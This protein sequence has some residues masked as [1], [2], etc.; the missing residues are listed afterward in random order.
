VR[1][2]CHKSSLPLLTLILATSLTASAQHLKSRTVERAESEG[3]VA[4]TGL[5]IDGQPGLPNGP[6]VAGKDW[7]KSLRLDIK[8]NHDTAIVYMS[9]ELE[10][11]PTGKMQHPLR[12]PIHFGR[13]PGNANDTRDPKAVEKLAPKKMKRLAIE[14]YMYDFLV[15]YMKE[16][17]VNDIER[18]QMYVEIIIFDDGTAWGKGGHLM[19]QDPKNPDRWVVGG[20]WVD[21]SISSLRRMYG[22]PPPQPPQR[23]PPA[24]NTSPR[25]CSQPTKNRTFS[26]ASVAYKSRCCRSAALKKS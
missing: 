11:A 18:V 23:Q 8:N 12:L 5:E 4:V 9:V 6:V 25:L 16:N 1:L 24:Q 15:K 13:R 7:L 3:P 20:M 17:G 21:R 22:S 19:R 14:G 26:F 10:I 2:P